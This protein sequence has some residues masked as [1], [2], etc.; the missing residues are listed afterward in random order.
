MELRF[1]APEAIAASRT[2]G[3]ISEREAS[4]MRATKGLAATDSGTMAATVPR[5]VPTIRRERG[6]TSTIRIMKGKDL[7][8]LINRSAIF[9]TIASCAAW[10]ES[11]SL[12][13]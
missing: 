4:T 1:E 2:P 10:P 8:V 13:R 12:A 9:L 6:R 7:R 11:L 3:S 5:L